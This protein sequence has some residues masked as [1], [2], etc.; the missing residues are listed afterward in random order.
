MEDCESDIGFSNDK[1]N[2]DLNKSRFNK[3]GKT[4]T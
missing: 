3:M 4:K 2:I 1:V